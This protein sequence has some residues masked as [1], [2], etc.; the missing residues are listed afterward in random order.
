MAPH[1]AAPGASCRGAFKE[2][3]VA[4]RQPMFSRAHLPH[5][6]R[7]VEWGCARAD[8]SATAPSERFQL[9]WMGS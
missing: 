3:A 1:R 4:A 6:L 7:P 9:P 8:R 2:G 5:R